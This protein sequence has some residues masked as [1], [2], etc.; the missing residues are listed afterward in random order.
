[1]RAREADSLDAVDGVA[2]AQQLAELRAQLGCEVAAPGVDV[3]AEQRDLL[4]ALLRKPRHLGDDLAGAA[5]L[6]PAANS[7]HDAIRADRVAAHRHLHPCLEGT[8]AVVGKRRGEGAVVEPDAPARHP[9][10]AGA[11]PVTEMRDR[12]RPE[13]DVDARI[14]LEDALAL[15]LGVAAADRDHALRVVALPRKRVAE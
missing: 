9:P 8:L 14:Q 6:F 1:M 11:E 12:A 10:A 2:G 4:D 15:G 13:R 3:L 5:T 7:R